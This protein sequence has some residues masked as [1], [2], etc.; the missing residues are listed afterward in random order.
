MDINR[1][2]HMQMCMLDKISIPLEIC[3]Y[4]VR[5]EIVCVLFVIKDMTGK[6]GG[7]GSVE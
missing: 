5:T 4:D 6:R 7:G 3:L 2:S 1:Q